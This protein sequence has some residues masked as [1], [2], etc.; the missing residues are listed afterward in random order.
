MNGESPSILFPL[1]F[2]ITPPVV[3]ELFDSGALADSI[4]PPRSS[5]CSVSA[6]QLITLLHR[7]QQDAFSTLLATVPS[8][9]LLL[10]SRCSPWFFLALPL[11][12]I[13]A[14][15]STTIGTKDDRPPGHVG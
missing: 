3:L 15:R 4:A 9:L 6:G 2:S 8:P 11:R 10:A 14:D 12:L 13:A 1:P 7:Q 5:S